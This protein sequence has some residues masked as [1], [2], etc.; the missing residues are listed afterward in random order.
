MADKNYKN[1]SEVS[2]QLKINKHV[3]RYWDSKFEGISTRL[4]DNKRRFQIASMY[5]EK[6]K[7]LPIILPIINQSHVFHLYVIRSDKRVELQNFL[8]KKGVQTL[9]HYPIPPH[10]QKSYKE[11]N[12]IQLPITE[13]IHNTVLS[14]PISPVMNDMEVDYVCKQIELFFS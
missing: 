6:L 3:I 12:K 8:E 1:I 9:I 10:L 7:K 2:E 5:N 13:E 14:L 11:F 4:S